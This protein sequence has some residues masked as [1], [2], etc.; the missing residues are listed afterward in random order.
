MV[1]VDE[2]STQVAGE[3]RDILA[4]W[5][6]RWGVPGLERRLKITVS[7]RLRM[8]LGRC[9]PIR[10]EIRIASFLLDAPAS[11][12]HEVLCHE[13]AHVA[14]AELHG[15]SVRPHGREWRALMWAA[16]FEPRVRLKV[17]GLDRL[18]GRV[19][20]AR[21]MWEH[22]CPVCQLGKLARRPVPQWRCADCR[23]A[24]LKGELVITRII[25]ARQSAH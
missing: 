19:R 13:A 14:V 24:G 20:Q 21:A 18:P 11:L 2:L 5:C 25:D 9:S 15:R 17:E 22:H 1:M 23:E 7:R 8:S 10:G 12:V 16:G 3:W 6:R 4:P